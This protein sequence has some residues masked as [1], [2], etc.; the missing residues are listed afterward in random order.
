MTE[1]GYNEVLP[2]VHCLHILLREGYGEF[3]Y[4]IALMEAMNY[5]H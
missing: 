3:T 5:I 1:I 2:Q 4:I